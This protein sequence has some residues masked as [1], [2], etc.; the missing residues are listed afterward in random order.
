MVSSAGS[1]IDGASATGK[2]SSPLGEL[3]VDRVR[4]LSA[5]PTREA[6]LGGLLA[7]G[8][9]L[10]LIVGFYVL[11]LI[12]WAIGAGDAP[13]MG[14]LIGF[15]AAHGGALFAKVPPVPEL[16]GIGGSLKI[17][18]PTTSIALLPF[19]LLLVGSWV[20]SRRER[21]FVVFALV[22]TV[23][24][25]FILAV[26]ALLSRATLSAGEGTEITF[27]A[28]P[29]SAA[30]HGLLIAGLGTLVGLVAARGPFLPDRARQVLRGALVAVGISVILAMLLAM[31]VLAGTAVP[32]NPLEGLRQDGDSQPSENAQ[33]DG[34][35]ASDGGVRD[36]ISGVAAAIGGVFALL[37]AG[38][39]T[40]WLLAHGLP[41]GLQNAPDLS[42]IPLVGEAL[43]DVKLSASLLGHWPFAGTWRL[44]LLAPVVGL[45]LG[46]AVAAHDA[47]PS[48]R[49][50]Y[51]AL[52]AIPYTTIVLL[53]AILA[54]LS[55][56]L[57]VA[58]LDLDVAFG[59]SLAWTLLVMPVAAG[60]GAAGA[61]LA[62][63]G[64][65]PAPHPQWVGVITAC[66]C[67]VLLLGTLPLV[68]SSSSDVPA[69]DEAL[70]PQSDPPAKSSVPAPDLEEPPP[71]TEN[72]PEPDFSPSPKPPERPDAP[73]AT[74][75]PAQQ[76]FISTYY[77]AVA[78]EDWAA[79][80]SML[81]PSSQS[82]VTREEW[83]REQQAREDASDEPPIQSARITQMSKQPG[84]F[85][86]TVEITHDDGTKTTV[87]GV[88]IQS[89]GGEFRR[90][91]TREE[92]GEGS[93]L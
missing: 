69:P 52:I 48:H 47:P 55:V 44:L 83:I 78:R 61:L 33:P 8:V 15:V 34:S 56:S 18:P 49:W 42:G 63:R 62:R 39:G 4:S 12:R 3:S 19:V 36:T 73:Q 91:L 79:T 68:A 11:L 81:D 85:T 23:C 74:P 26:V 76:R 20:L 22:A 72:V 40:L 59:A 17:D 80:Y 89:V 21:S 82:K 45:V 31:L 41:V 24:Y 37:P 38:V 25:S 46:G 84:H 93:P 88:K 71:A 29:L 64:S 58:G 67:S 54:S 53:T 9:A 35:R 51:G 92:L 65:I 14:G 70:A 86:L 50:R 30:L 5:E 66:A 16:L 28:T 27:S 57:S 77:A 75:T 10:A 6:L 7:L 2:R 60:L 90:H 43:K 13:G 1:S 32:D 87:P